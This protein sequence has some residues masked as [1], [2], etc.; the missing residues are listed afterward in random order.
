M[1]KECELTV[2]SP[3]G[4]ILS[5]T[6]F[7]ILISDVGLWTDATV[8]GY[9]DDTTSTISGTDLDLLKTRCEEEASKIIEYMSANKLAANCDKTHV[10]AIRRSG[11]KDE[12][13]IQVGEDK[14][15][16]SP[17]EKLLGIWVENN[18]TWST[19]LSKLEKNLKHRLFSLRRLSEQIPRVLLKKVAD[20]IFMSILRYGLP[21]YCPLRFK[22]DDPK[23]SSIDNIN[24][25]FN[26]CLR[27]LTNR[28]RKVTKAN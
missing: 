4:A 14:I 3:Q 20:G 25:V 9:A 2:G 10:M 26:D 12:I 19:H 23:H 7:I 28:R 16:E 21:L 27:L 6:I 13:V 8:F 18:L 17:N 1:S 24:V 22:D 15:K 5:P 11:P